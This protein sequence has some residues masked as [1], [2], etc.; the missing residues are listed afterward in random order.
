MK[1]QERQA[2]SRQQILAAA[3]AEFSRQDYD[4]VTMER[5][6]AAHGISKGMM[7]HYYASKDELFLLCVE[8]TF[9]AL[10]QYIARGTQALAEEKAPDAIKQFFL[11]RELFFEEQPQRKRIFETAMLNPPAHLKEKITALHAPISEMNRVV[12]SRLMACVPLREGLTPER[13]A[14]YLESV[15]RALPVAIGC[16]AQE[17]P[18]KLHDVLM[19]AQ[20]LLDMALFGIWQS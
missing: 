6:C 8:D 19:I 16:Y 3:M 18:A 10:A 5:I 20:E 11:L 12:L 9:S 15:E 4:K 13:A 2:R 7:Y 1:Q 14:R 17:K